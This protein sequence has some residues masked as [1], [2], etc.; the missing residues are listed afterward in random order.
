MLTKRGLSLGSRPGW[1]V[2]SALMM[3]R[4]LQGHVFVAWRVSA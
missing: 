4:F 1:R 3:I 2:T